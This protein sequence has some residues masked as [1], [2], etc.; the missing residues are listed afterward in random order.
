LFDLPQGLYD[1][2]CQA[3]YA[4]LADNHF[5]KAKSNIKKIES[6]GLG[7]PGAFQNLCTYQDAPFKFGSGDD[8]IDQLKNITCDFDKYMEYSRN[9][10]KYVETMWLENNIDQ[11]KALYYTGYGTKERNEMSPD[12]IRL[13]PDQ[14]YA[15]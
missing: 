14:K 3:V 13:N 8:L 2:K 4:P 10:R 11:H 6:G 1:T 15:G 9:A 12:L 5:N 7:I